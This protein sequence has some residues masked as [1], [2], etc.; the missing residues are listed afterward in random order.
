[1]EERRDVAEMEQFK[2]GARSSKVG[3]G[4]K[5]EGDCNGFRIGN[6]WVYLQT[7]VRS[8]F[9][10]KLAERRSEDNPKRSR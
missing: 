3:G 7:I 2:D 8:C 5:I 9:L 1:M 6:M 10:C 4:R